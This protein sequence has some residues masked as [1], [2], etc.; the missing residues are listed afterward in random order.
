MI[1]PVLQIESGFKL[2]T[3]EISPDGKLLG[4]GTDNGDV[5]INKLIFFSVGCDLADHLV[6]DGK[7]FGALA[8]R[9]KTAMDKR[10]KVDYNDR[11]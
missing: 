9:F 7:V 4:A 8:G 5:G 6:S 11:L 2:N 1:E 3:I 10:S